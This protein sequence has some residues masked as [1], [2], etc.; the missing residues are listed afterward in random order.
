MDRLMGTIK[1]IHKLAI[2]IQRSKAMEKQ[3]H[4]TEDT[5]MMRERNEEE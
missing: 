2:F 4:S 3:G 1:G 5:P